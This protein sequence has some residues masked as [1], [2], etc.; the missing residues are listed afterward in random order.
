MDAGAI[1]PGPVVPL[2]HLLIG[3]LDEGAM[4]VARAADPEAARREVEGVLD[5]LLDGIAVR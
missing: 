4:F 3:A 5:R 1:A 2:A